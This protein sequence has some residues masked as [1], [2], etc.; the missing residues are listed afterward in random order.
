MKFGMFCMFFQVQVKMK[1]PAAAIKDPPAKRPA[2]KTPPSEGGNALCCCAFSFDFVSPGGRN[3][4]APYFDNRNG[5]WGLK[6]NG[7][8]VVLA[9]WHGIGYR[10]WWVCFGNR[11]V[12][13][14]VGSWKLESCV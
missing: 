7:K 6:L 3:V 1:R 14:L 2:V 5:K 9:T 13:V 4:S 12:T 11:F 10:M 8:Q